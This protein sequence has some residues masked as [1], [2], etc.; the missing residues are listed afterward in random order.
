MPLKWANLKGEPD[1]FRGSTAFTYTD[2]SLWQWKTATSPRPMRDSVDK[3]DRIVFHDNASN[4]G[5]FLLG[6]NVIG[7]FSQAK[8]D[9]KTLVLDT[10]IR[11]LLQ[12]RDQPTGISPLG[13]AVS[14]QARFDAGKR[15]LN[16]WVSHFE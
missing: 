4:L 2:G 11:C 8:H 16:F 13:E 15:L 7:A 14:I 5:G 1:N 12:G 10:S 9:R 3:I 6:F